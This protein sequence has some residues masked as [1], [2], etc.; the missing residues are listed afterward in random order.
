VKGALATLVLL[1]PA[2]ALACPACALHTPSGPGM[3]AL[4]AAMIAVPYAV[5]VVALKVIRRL[6]SDGDAP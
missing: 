6:A 5:A 4:I 2:P 3:F 1:A